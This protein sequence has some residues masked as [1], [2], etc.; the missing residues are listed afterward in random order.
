[1]PILKPKLPGGRVAIAVRIFYVGGI[2][3]FLQAPQY[4]VE[5]KN[6][7]TPKEDMDTADQER[8]QQGDERPTRNSLA[9]KL[10]TW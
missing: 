5:C 3:A 1:M 10:R 6:P 7:C 8:P 4:N 2:G 9:E